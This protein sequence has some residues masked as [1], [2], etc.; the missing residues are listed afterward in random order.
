MT[1]RLLSIVLLLLLRHGDDTQLL[2]R[3]NVLQ[4]SHVLLLL[5][6]HARL[7]WEETCDGLLLRQQT[8]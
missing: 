5:L 1:P 2:L 6:L 4:L 7:F 3:A 8:K